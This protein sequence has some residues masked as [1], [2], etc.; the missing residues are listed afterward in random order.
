MGLHGLLKNCHLDHSADDNNDCNSP[1]ETVQSAQGPPTLTALQPSYLAPHTTYIY[2]EDWI[3]RKSLNSR[4]LKPR[5]HLP[6]TNTAAEVK[7]SAP[8]VI[9][10][11]HL[12]P[13]QQFRVSRLHRRAAR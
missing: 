13:A 10:T 6:I 2:S 1:G 9:R 12:H 4:G 8:R 5:S 3:H 11:E 7:A